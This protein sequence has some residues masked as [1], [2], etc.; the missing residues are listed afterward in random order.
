MSRHQQERTMA[1]KKA[2]SKPKK[3]K[4]AAKKSSKKGAC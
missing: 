2:P 3:S 1:S 4:P